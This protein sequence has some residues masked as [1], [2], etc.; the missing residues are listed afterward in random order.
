MAKFCG[1]HN[2]VV[3]VG[4]A[5]R[6][7]ACLVSRHD[8]WVHVPI[9]MQKFDAFCGISTNG[10]PCRWT[11]RLLKHSAHCETMYSVVV[12]VDWVGFRLRVPHFL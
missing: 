7:G 5:A 11:W 10:T 1:L 6:D 2:F 8:F 3:H 4:D 12:G 9:G